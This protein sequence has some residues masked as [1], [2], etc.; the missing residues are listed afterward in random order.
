M[1]I[2]ESD[3]RRWDFLANLMNLEG[4]KSFVEVGCKEGRTTGHILANVPESRVIAIDPWIVQPR[5]ETEAFNSDRETYDDWSFEQIEAE[6]W[7]NAGAHRDT[8]RLDFWRMTSEEAAA[9][10]LGKT[11]LVFID[12]LHDYEHVKQDIELW[13]PKV[14]VGGLITG[15]DYQHKFPGTMRAVA[16]KFCLMDVGC[17]PDSVWFIR[18]TG[19]A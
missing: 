18:K 6:F 7:K 10:Y 11:D 13:W 14:R 2:I 15:H 4:F 17:G 12:A 16:E 8:P 9:K 3:Q 5:L 19:E 1:K